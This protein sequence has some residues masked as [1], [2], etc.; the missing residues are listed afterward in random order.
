MEAV[1][2][3]ADRES[4]SGKWIPENSP[5]KPERSVRPVTLRERPRT[6][7]GRPVTKDRGEQTLYAEH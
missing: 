1:Q 5:K 6:T 3:T 2:W 4:V 7:E